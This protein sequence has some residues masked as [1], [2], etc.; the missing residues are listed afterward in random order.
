MIILNFLGNLS[1]YW[2]WKWIVFC[3]NSD[4]YFLV[5]T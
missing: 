2:Y 3:C 1:E 4:E 5:T